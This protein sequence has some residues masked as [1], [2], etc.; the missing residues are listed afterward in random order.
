MN[1]NFT[2][3]VDSSLAL[4]TSSRINM[5]S[6]VVYVR[7][8]FA[9]NSEF[10]WLILSSYFLFGFHSSRRFSEMLLTCRFVSLLLGK[11]K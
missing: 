8:L 11:V 3:Q 6:Y 5:P 7:V 9:S 10:S 2:F 1:S 4:A